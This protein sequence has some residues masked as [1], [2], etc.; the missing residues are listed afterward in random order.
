MNQNYMCK[1]A[2]HIVEKGKLLGIQPVLLKFTYESDTK[3]SDTYKFPGNC[4]LS[5]VIAASDF[6]A[7]VDEQ[8]ESN[9]I[10]SVGPS[11]LTAS[12]VT[13]LAKSGDFPYKKTSFS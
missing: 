1:I 2:I 3:V 4:F 6:L 7:V 9:G 12:Q 10:C 13:G 11:Y 5:I 8:E